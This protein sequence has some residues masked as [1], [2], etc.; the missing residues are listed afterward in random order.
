MENFKIGDNVIIKSN[1]IWN[2]KTGVILKISNELDENGLHQIL[3]V[4]IKL[5]LSDNT[6]KYINQIFDSK[7]VLLF[8]PIASSDLSRINEESKSELSYEKFLKTFIGKICIFKGF[9]YNKIFSK[10]R[11]EDNS[12]DYNRDDKE[13]I[14][15]YRSLEGKK[16][17]LIKCVLNDSY[18]PELSIFDNFN[19]CFWDIYFN[20][21]DVE[22]SAVCGEYLDLTDTNI[23]INEDMNLKLDYIHDYLFSENI[24]SRTSAWIFADIIASAEDKSIDSIIDDSKL[25]KYKIFLL[26]DSDIIKYI[27]ANININLDDVYNDYIDYAKGDFKVKEIVY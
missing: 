8:N 11:Q 12:F 3:K 1:G 4:K 15:Y 20:D 27:I 18:D 24:D 25:F 7:D 5:I 19:N 17:I 21:I 16:C 9:D 23:G 10:E 6:I 2:N 26:K 14:D 22:L 13:I